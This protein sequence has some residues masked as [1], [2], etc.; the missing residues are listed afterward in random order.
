M[1]HVSSSWNDPNLLVLVCMTHLFQHTP[2][3]IDPRRTPQSCAISVNESKTD[4]R[5]FFTKSTF[6]EF[7]RKHGLQWLNPLKAIKIHYFCGLFHDFQHSFFS[8][9]QHFWNFST[10]N[11]RRILSSV[12]RCS[13]HDESSLCSDR[14]PLLLFSSSREHRVHCTF[15]DDDATA[16]D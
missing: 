2:N 14:R 12:P 16:V 5:L 11:F 8:K 6:I 4:N 10:R 9:I 7:S 15:F 13:N 3:E 1:L